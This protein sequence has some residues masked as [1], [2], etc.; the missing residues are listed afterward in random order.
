MTGAESLFHRWPFQKTQPQHPDA[1]A[2]NIG[3]IKL[4]MNPGDAVS[5]LLEHL[6]EAWEIPDAAPAIHAALRSK[7]A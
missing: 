5:F 6:K 1:W 2:N 7:A 3:A 4:P